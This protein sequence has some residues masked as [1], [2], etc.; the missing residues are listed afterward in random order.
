MIMPEWLVTTLTVFIGLVI[1]TGLFGLL[2]PGFPGIVIIWIATLGYGI[3]VGFDTLGIVLF[4]VITLLMIAGVTVDNVL[5]GA[6][7]RMGGA[8]W[9]TVI[10]AV[11]AGVAGTLIFPPFGGLAAA[12][13]AIFLVEYWR[14]R[15]GRQAW[16]ATLGLAAGFG[17]SFFVRFLIGALMFTLWLV[18]VWQG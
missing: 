10:I 15:D 5:M 12:P 18:W 17:A 4:I 6:G 1:L 3:L 7:A 8:A 9:R 16:R 13:L 2:I 14:V 11:V